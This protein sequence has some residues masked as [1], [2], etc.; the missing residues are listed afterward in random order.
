MSGSKQPRSASAGG[1]TGGHPGSSS[2]SFFFLLRERSVDSLR[3]GN[4]HQIS[5]AEGPR[6]SFRWG[7]SLSPRIAVASGNLEDKREGWMRLAKAQENLAM[8]YVVKSKKFRSNG[9]ISRGHLGEVCINC[10]GEMGQYVERYGR[11]EDSR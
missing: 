2:A 9:E 1:V 7:C 11:G 5:R 4:Q 8:P 10:K 3:G 6:A